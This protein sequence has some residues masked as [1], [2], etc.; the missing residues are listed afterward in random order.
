MTLKKLRSWTPKE[1]AQIIAALLALSGVIFVSVRQS[2]SAS[3]S[4]LKYMVKQMNEDVIPRIEDQLD[5]IETRLDEMLERV[6]KLEAKGE[7]R[8][9][10]VRYLSK[11]ADIGTVFPSLSGDIKK[12]PVELPRLQSQS[13]QLEE[14]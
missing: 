4:E 5:K 6:A 10:T 12:K 11:L 14:K 1:Y 8:A 2:Y 13:N 3:S 7:Q 9:A